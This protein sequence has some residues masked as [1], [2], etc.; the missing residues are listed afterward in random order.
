MLTELPAG[1]GQAP[2]VVQKTV[3]LLMLLERR[4]IAP[5]GSPAESPTS[6][7]PEVSCIDVSNETLDVSVSEGDVCRFKNSGK[8]IGS[9]I[10]SLG[11]E[12]VSKAVCESNGGYE[13]QLV[14]SPRE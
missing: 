12:R 8:S 13:R 2:H 14:K 11:R 3:I 10:N 1:W 6:Q 4:Q 5:V 7:V 9:L